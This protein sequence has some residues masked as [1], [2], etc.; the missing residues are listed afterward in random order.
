M[1]IHCHSLS[2]MSI[3]LLCPV[4]YAVKGKHIALFMGPYGEIMHMQTTSHT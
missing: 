3:T 4:R 1:N 2:R